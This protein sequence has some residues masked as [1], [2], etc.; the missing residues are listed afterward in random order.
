MPVN[1]F[2]GRE[3]LCVRGERA[4]F[5]G[6][7]FA[8]NAGGALLLTG[9]NGS[10]K[11]S[12]L[13]LMAGLLKPAGGSVSWDGKAIGE[14][15]ERFRAELRYLGHLDA[16]KPALSVAENLAAFAGLRGLG[17]AAVEAA[18]DRLGLAPL[19]ALPA[20]L[21]SAGQKRRLALARLLLGESRLWLLDEP[22]VGLDSGAIERLESIVVEQRALGGAVVVATHQALALPGANEIALDDFALKAK[23]P[24][25]WGGPT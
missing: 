23:P 24:F 3:L 5:G 17:A 2:E 22:T 25:S 13:R 10:G 9:R 14:D 12:L 21:L 16:V 19:E 1:L 4:V 18:L 8:L 7:D 6:L 11:S 15:P 20:R